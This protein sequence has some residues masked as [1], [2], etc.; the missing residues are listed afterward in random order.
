[1]ITSNILLLF[2]LVLNND[3]EWMSLTDTISTMLWNNDIVDITMMASP[4]H[5]TLHGKIKGKK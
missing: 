1:M 4:G 5:H 2:G 3:Y